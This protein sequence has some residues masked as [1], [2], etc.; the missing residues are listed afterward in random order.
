MI[1]GLAG[2]KQSGKDTVGQYLVDNYGFTRFA[3]ADK[4]KE[5]VAT[6]LDIPLEQLEQYKNN[7]EVK[8]VL[9]V[10]YNREFDD[11]FKELSVRD[12]YKRMGTEVGRNI[13]DKDLWWRLLEDQVG[14]Y[15]VIT[16]V[17]FPNEYDWILRRGGR[18]IHMVRPQTEEVDS[19]ESETHELG[20]MHFRIVNNYM[21]YP[22]L[23]NDVDAY[24][25]ILGVEKIGS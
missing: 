12:L 11:V 8:L 2:K 18:M 6:L 21:T 16:D 9:G 14:E 20:S 13:L 15:A 5:C 4:V 1:I 24:M 3:F 7:D 25:E 17:R 22:F 19:H 23:Y 10:Y